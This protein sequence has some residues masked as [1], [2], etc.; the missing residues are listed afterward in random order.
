MKKTSEIYLKLNHSESFVGTQRKPLAPKHVGSE[1]N[2]IKEEHFGRP[3]FAG[4]TKMI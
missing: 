2:L 4:E 1:D 3:K